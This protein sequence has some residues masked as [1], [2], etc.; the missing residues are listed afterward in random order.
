MAL[1]EACVAGASGS[2]VA[3]TQSGCC[4]STRPKAMRCDGPR[5]A[6]VQALAGLIL[7]RRDHQRLHRGLGVALVQRQKQAAEAP[8]ARRRYFALDRVLGLALLRFGQLDADEVIGD[9]LQADLGTLGRQPLHAAHDAERPPHLRLLP[10]RGQRAQRHGIDHAHRR[11][12]AKASLRDVADVPGAAR[13]GE[14]GQAAAGDFQR[15]HVLVAHAPEGGDLDRVAKGAGAA[16]ALDERLRFFFA[17]ETGDAG[18]TDDRIHA[19]LGT[20][21]LAAAREGLELGIDLG[22]ELGEQVQLVGTARRALGKRVVAHLLIQHHHILH[23]HRVQRPGVEKEHPTLERLRRAT[24]ESRA[25]AEIDVEAGHGRRLE[26]QPQRRAPFGELLGDPFEMA[27][28]EVAR[29]DQLQHQ[30]PHVLLLDGR[31]SAVGEHR[32]PPGA[33]AAPST[34]SGTA[35]AGRTTSPESIARS[36]TGGPWHRG[37]GA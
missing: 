20:G 30:N 27:R 24:L 36:G 2:T 10:D 31:Q 6:H 22:G 37:P 13:S 15:A 34:P 7:A 3:H 4:S 9:Y 17:Q 18:E 16:P 26:G 14:I 29:I 12:Q 33:R 23:Q 35:R 25:R 11:H 1:V 28:R 32:R 19:A 8:V 5:G 21:A